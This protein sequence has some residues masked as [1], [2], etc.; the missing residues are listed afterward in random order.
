MIPQR[1]TRS[2]KALRT[3]ILILLFSFPLFFFATLAFAKEDT[4][5]GKMFKPRPSVQV[6]E[7][8]YSIDST[9]HPRIVNLKMENEEFSVITYCVTVKDLLT[10][11]GLTNIDEYKVKPDL[12]FKLT[13]NTT[14]SV[15]KFSTDRKIEIESIP[16][17]SITVRDNNIE[18]DTTQVLQSGRDGQRKV[19]YE[20]RYVDGVLVEKV[21][22]REETLSQVQNEIIGYGTKKVFREITIGGDTFKYWKKIRVYATSYDSSCAGCSNTTATGA[23][24]TKGVVAVDPSVIPLFTNMYVPGYGYGK[25]L[26]VGGAI[27]GNKIDLGFEDLSLVQ[28]QWSARY[29]DIYILD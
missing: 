9:F 10:E 12:D 26:D 14:I 19:V 27:K 16:Y 3:T 5:E 22:V 6:L 2:L 4:S 11:L 25:A 21:P 24:L 8:Y 20:Y 13:S 18:I 1:G 29:V 23:K 17:S 28:G 15:K 7:S